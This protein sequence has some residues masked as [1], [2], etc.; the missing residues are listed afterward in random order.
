[1][2]RVADLLENTEIL[3]ENALHDDTDYLKS[4]ASA[5]KQVSIVANKFMLKTSKCA[6]LCT[7]VQCEH[8]DCKLE[9]S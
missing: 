3:E 9:N 6:A 5:R 1:M 7:S 2:C 8:V 4:R